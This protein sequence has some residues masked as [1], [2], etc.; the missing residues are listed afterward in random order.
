MKGWGW[1]RG[2]D[3]VGWELCKVGNG[4]EGGDDVVWGWC[5]GGNGVGVGMV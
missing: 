3:G 1:C 5:G 2:G 4:Y